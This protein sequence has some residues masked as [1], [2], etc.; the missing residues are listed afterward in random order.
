[1]NY[2]VFSVVRLGEYSK[3]VII[4]GDPQLI[5]VRSKNYWLDNKYKL[6]EESLSRKTTYFLAFTK[7]KPSRNLYGFSLDRAH[8]QLFIKMVSDKSANVCSIEV[9]LNFP[10]L[11]LSN[12]D[13]KSIESKVETF[14]TWITISVWRNPSPTIEE[15]EELSRVPSSQ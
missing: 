10:W 3:T 5:L 4:N 8:R 11:F 9:F 12:N 14:L 13:L 1:M 2:F 7:E 15:S 6:V